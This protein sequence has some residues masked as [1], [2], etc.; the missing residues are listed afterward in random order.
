MRKPR[1]PWSCLVLLSAVYATD[2]KVDALQAEVDELRA[3]LTVER[4]AGESLE[5]WVLELHADDLERETVG[6]R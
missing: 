1:R 5:A 4:R 2:G 3:A 6:D